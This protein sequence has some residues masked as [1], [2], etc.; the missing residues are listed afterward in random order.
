MGLWDPPPPLLHAA[1][2]ACLCRRCQ[3]LE[4]PPPADPGEARQLVLQRRFFGKWQV[5]KHIHG[6]VGLEATVGDTCYDAKNAEWQFL[7]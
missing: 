1:R 2:P 4:I 3:N 6:F 5:L 7:R